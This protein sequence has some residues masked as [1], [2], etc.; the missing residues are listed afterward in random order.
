MGD[1]VLVFAEQSDGKFRKV[2]IE[3]V[4]EGKRLADKLGAE[5]SAAV[6]GS[7]VQDVAT[8]LGAYGAAKVYVVDDPALKDYSPE[9]Y[10]KALARIVNETQPSILLM[11]CT[12]T[13]RDLGPRVAARLATG[14]APD[15]TA[16]DVN[17][18][19][20]LVM[21]RPMFAGRAIAKVVCPDS[22][23][24]IASIRPNVFAAADP[25]E[26]KTAE[27]VKI[28]AEISPD[29]LRTLVREVIKS[30]GT[31]IDLT[32]AQV[33]VSGGRGLGGPENFKILEELAEALGAA[34]GASRAA[35]DAGWRDHQNQV[36][37]T[38]KTVSP[39][40]YIACGISGAI[41]HLAGMKTSKVIVAVNKDPEAPIFKVADYGIV[42]DV[43]EVVPIMTEEAKK[44]LA[45][46]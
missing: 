45:E 7:G 29:E 5:L 28:E 16:L 33:I 41:Q 26:G 8:S 17:D 32:E 22:T 20:K 18:G 3:A 39:V 27:V 13:G 25:D 43:F 9:G 34:V 42:G 21:T 14:I 37:Q 12:A 36:G 30:A 44:L 38:G 35:V 2:A 15:C 4:S 11:G 10:T 31:A 23:P 40:L 24:Q 1:G 6:I 46:Q 19:G